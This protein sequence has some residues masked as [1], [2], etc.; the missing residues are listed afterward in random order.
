[1]GFSPLGEEDGWIER[2]RRAL[3]DGGAA[4]PGCL[5]AGNASR[6]REVILLARTK[7]SR[8]KGR[9][10]SKGRRRLAAARVGEVADG[11]GD[12]IQ[13]GCFKGLRRNGLGREAA[14]LGAGQARPW[15]ACSYSP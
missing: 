15:R 11:A 5:G 7:Q 4:G 8:A 10:G 3:R 13:G 14:E 12:E 9:R 1:M 2:A 6:R